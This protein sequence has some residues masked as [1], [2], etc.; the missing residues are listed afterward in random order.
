VLSRLFSSW[1]FWIV[2]S[3]WDVGVRVRMGKVAATLRPGP[4]LR[5]PGLDEIVMVNTRLRM[6]STPTVT[7][8][9]SNANKTRV[10]TANVA[11]TVADPVRAMLAYTDSASALAALAQAAIATGKTQEEALAALREEFGAHGVDVSA[12]YYTENVEVRTLRLMQ[13][14]GGV[15]MGG[16]GYPVAPGQPVHY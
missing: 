16:S 9:G 15:Y 4:H 8:A 1:K 5:I 6:C 10:V 3:P 13:G 7:I 12:V 14:G 11:F 2:V